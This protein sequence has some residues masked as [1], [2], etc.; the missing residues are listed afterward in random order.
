MSNI[1]L[2]DKEFSIYISSEQIQSRVAQI[3]EQLNIDFEGKRPLFI[4]VLN[5]AFLFTADLFKKITIE[6]ELSFIRLS[7][8]EG[9]QSTGQVKELI[10]IGKEINNRHVIIIEDI[11]DTGN[12]AVHLMKELK[13]HKPAELRIATL[14]LKPAALKH[15]INIDYCGFEIPN[16]FILGYGLDYDGLGRNLNNIYKLVR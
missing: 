16:D 4:G 15:H 5:G 8:Y 7:S 14:L 1:R 9:M 3:A 11:V 2:R 6:C 10:G 13:K 12:T